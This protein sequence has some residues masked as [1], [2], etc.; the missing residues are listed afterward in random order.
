[1]RRK[2]NYPPRRKL[3]NKRQDQQEITEAISNGDELP[4][5]QI[6]FIPLTKNTKVKLQCKHE[7][8]CTECVRD[9]YCKSQVNNRIY[10]LP[11]K[12]SPDL[13]LPV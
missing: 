2:L 1:M 11:V 7:Y 10:V 6:C 9:W 12:D 4:E 3:S 5:C 8:Y 13:N